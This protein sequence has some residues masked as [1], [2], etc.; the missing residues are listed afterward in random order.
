MIVARTGDDRAIIGA[1]QPFSDR[2]GLRA[3][4]IASAER[5][6][7]VLRSTRRHDARAPPVPIRL[8]MPLQ[9]LAP[10]EVGDG[11]P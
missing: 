7:R 9:R 4:I 6:K 8:L 1:Q 5:R 2:F 3:F 10:G 11:G